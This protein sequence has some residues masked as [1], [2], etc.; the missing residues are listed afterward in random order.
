MSDE[1][2]HIDVESEEFEDAPKALRDYVK[3]LQAQD[4]KR[5]D[6]LN[7]V[8]GQLASRAVA[9]VLADKG[10]KNPERVKR[11]ILADGIDPTDKAAVDGWL[12]ENSDDYARAEA[13]A[14]AAT[15][16]ST[17]S[18]TVPTEVQQ[19][20]RNLNVAGS[21]A[22]ADPQAVYSQITKEMDGKDVIALFKQHGL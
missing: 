5:S 4:R 3:K 14:A 17:E 21:P 20:Y 6:E 16:E 12:S 19:N 13:A 18:T 9:D 8:R 15:E 2:K 22:G 11:D 1:L 10:F 7:Q